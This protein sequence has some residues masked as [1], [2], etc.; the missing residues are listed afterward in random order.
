MREGS[1]AEN[2]IK[3]S[4]VI[5]TYNSS[6]TL[7]ATLESVK[8]LDEI[9]ICDMYSTDDTLEI[10]KEY[11]AKIVMFENCGFVEPARNFALSAASN[12]WCFVL[13][14]DEVAPAKLIDF[15]REAS[16]QTEY[17]AY[18]LLRVEIHLGKPLRSIEDHIRRF[19]RKSKTDWPT[20]I[21]SIPTINGKVFILPTKQRDLSIEHYVVFSVSN[22]IEKHNGYTDKEVMRKLNKKKYSSIFCTCLSALSYVLKSYILK[23]AFRDGKVGFYHTSM[24]V[25]YKFHVLFKIWEKQIVDKLESK[26]L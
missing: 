11:G 9:V 21:H 25:I 20:T 5:N 7:R 12:D 3:I 17:D 24:I 2:N 4:A 23:G 13:D 16:L 1:P 26:N 18:S 19:M 14:S 15:I 8:S 6:K 10:A 22:L